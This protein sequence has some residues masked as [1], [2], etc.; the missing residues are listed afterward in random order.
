MRVLW[1]R[2]WVAVRSK[3]SNGT[4]IETAES[5]ERR[6]WLRQLGKTWR[7]GLESKAGRKGR[8]GAPCSQA[9][10][11]LTGSLCFLHSLRLPLPKVSS[12]QWEGKRHRSSKLT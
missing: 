2:K 12:M 9:L 8:A 3:E 4:L 7:L 1:G 11:S 10:G 6:H 5:K